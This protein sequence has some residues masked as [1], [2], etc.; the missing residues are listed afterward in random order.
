MTFSRMVIAA[1]VLVLSQT[2]AMA[3]EPTQPP[4]TRPAGG[5]P[6]QLQR[7]TEGLDG[8]NLTD[9]Q[10]AQV[11]EIMANFR[12]QMAEL[13]ENGKNLT[14]VER[15]E[16]VAT[17][18]RDLRQQLMQVLDPEQQKEL[19]KLIGKAE[20]GFPL[21]ERLKADLEKLDLTA[22]QK[23]DIAEVFRN[24]E[25]TIR[26]ILEKQRQGENVQGQLQQLREDVR[27]KLVAILTPEQ[28]AQLKEL[29]KAQKPTSR[30]ATE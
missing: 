7:L 19:A 29:L 21:L 20:E 2:L 8:L 30:P 6:A 18:L 14:P 4:T 10:K 26:G 23:T 24:A 11:K 28:A 13:R 25:T 5:V 9:A 17:L 3:A 27:T 16:K 15:R 12:K 22:D 1:L